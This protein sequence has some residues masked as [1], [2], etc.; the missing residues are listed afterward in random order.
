MEEDW[1]T[2]LSDKPPTILR[3]YGESDL[4]ISNREFNESE[5]HGCFDPLTVLD[6]VRTHVNI[7][8]EK[9]RAMPMTFALLKNPEENGM[10]VLVMSA[11]EQVGERVYDDD[12]NYASGEVAGDRLHVCNDEKLKDLQKHNVI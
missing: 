6:E 1:E 9:L 7:W 2:E 10:P 12:T 8:N 4:T 5:Q 11:N 3:A